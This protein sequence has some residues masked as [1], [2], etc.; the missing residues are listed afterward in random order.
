MTRAATWIKMLVG[1]VG[2][3][4]G[5]PAFTYWVMPTEDE[6]F[7]RYNPELQKRS[8]EKREM[9][10]QEFDNFVNKLKDWSKSDKPIWE[11]AS[12]IN[13]QHVAEQRQ[14]I[15][16]DKKSLAAD[17]ERRRREMAESTGEGP[18]A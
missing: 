1:G 16:D 10:E 6:L 4:V 7:K 3:C 13:A 12:E 18:K 17:V 15:I 14:K 2:L 9:R 11:A 5:G 8:L